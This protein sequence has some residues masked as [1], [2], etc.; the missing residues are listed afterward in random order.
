[1]TVIVNV[2][3]VPVQPFADGVTV[4]VAVTGLDVAFVAVNA[5]ILPEPLAARP[6]EVVL[7]VSC[8]YLF[9]S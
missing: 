6:N 3:A 4:I 2:W 1:M 7:F 9:I 8:S 5:A